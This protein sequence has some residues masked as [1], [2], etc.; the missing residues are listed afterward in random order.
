M[1]KKLTEQF[2]RD[3]T[4][5][6]YINLDQV[7]MATTFENKIRLYTNSG[8]IIDVLEPIEQV[9]DVEEVITLTD[10]DKTDGGSRNENGWVSNPA[11][12][13]DR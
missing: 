1:W 4:R 2:N 3:N 5:T 9:I 11:V 13:P 8:M 6:S 7:I 12:K 10:K